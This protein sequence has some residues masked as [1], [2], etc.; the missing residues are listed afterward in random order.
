MK[1]LKYIAVALFFSLLTVGLIV[2]SVPT[3]QAQANAESKNLSEFVALMQYIRSQPTPSDVLSNKIAELGPLD[4]FFTDIYI[5]GFITPFTG[6]SAE[7]AEAR[8]DSLPEDDRYIAAMVESYRLASNPLLLD[9]LHA[10]LARYYVELFTTA[11]L[12]GAPNFLGKSEIQTLADEFSSSAFVPPAPSAPGASVRPS[13]SSRSASD[14]QSA[15]LSEFAALMQYIRSQPT[16]SDVLSNKIAELG[17]LDGFFTDIY[18]DG[19]ITPFTGESAEEA[20]A[21]IDSLPEDDRYI[22]AMVE[23]YRLASNP[24]LLDI[25]HAVLA[26]YY[27]E[28]FTTA[29]LSGAPN[30]LGKSEIQT[31]ADDFDPEDYE[32]AMPSE[33][34]TVGDQVIDA[35]FGRLEVRSRGE[36]GRP[37]DSRVRVYEQASGTHLSTRDTGSDGLVTFYLRQGVY[38]VTVTET[39][40]IAVE[41]ID[42]E[43]GETSQVGVD[44][45]QLVL[46]YAE[47]AR[48]RLYDQASGT[49]LST[50]DVGSDGRASWHLRA[51]TYRVTTSNPAE[52]FTEISVLAGQTTVI[53]ETFNHPPVIES[54]SARPHLIKAGESTVI[55]VRASDK[56]LDTLTYTYTPSVGT[57]T[58]AGSRV[59]Y[60]APNTGGVYRID[61][62][63]SDGRG[64]VARTTLYVSGG[65]LKVTSLGGDD[66]RPLDSRV[67]VYEQASG[68]HVSTRDTGSDGVVE[69]R[70]IQG[71]YRITVSE[72]NS[73]SVDNLEVSPDRETAAQVFFGRLEVR[74]RGEG[75][76]P[77]DSRVRVYEQ[78]SGTHLST[79]DTGS[80]GLVTFYLRQGVYRVTVTET[81]AIAVENIDVEGGETS[82]VGV[83]FGQLV[84]IY[85][86]TA[87]ARLYD[88]AS[89]THLSTRDVGSDGRASWHLRAGTYRV[90]TSNPAEEFTEI[91]VLAGQTTVIGETFNHPPVIESAS[92]RPHLIKAGESTVITVRASDKDLDTLTYT[93]TPSVGTITGAGSRVTYTAPNTGGVYRIDIEV[94]D[95][96]GGVARTTLYVS[97]GVLKVTSLGGD[98]ERPLDS[99][100]RVYEQASG[101]HVSTRDTGSDGVVEFRLIQGTYRITVSETNSISVDNLE[102]SPD[103]ETA[104]QVFFGRLEVRSRGEGSRPLDSRVRVYE[105]ASGTHLSTRDTGSD[106]LV[107]FYLRQGVY[108]V[109]VTE[110]NAIAVENIDVEGGETSQV[111][112]DFGQLVLIYAETARA[113]LYDQASG[114]HLSTRDVGSDGRASWHLRAGTYRVTTSNPAEEFTEISVLAGQTTVIGETF[115]HPPVIE[116]ASARPHLIKAGESTVITV[117]ASDKDLDTLTYTYTPSVGTI[118]GAGSRV[119]YTAPNTGG[120]YRIDIEVSDGRGGVA[121][122]TLYVSGGVLKVT[123][124]GGD[125]ERPL[126]SRVRVYEQASGTHVSTRD[127]GS[128]GVVEFRLIQGTYRITVSET[129]SISVDNLEVSPDRETAAQV[130]F[131][132]LE[133]RSRGE[134]SRPLDSRV[135][136]YEQASGTHLS[137]RDTGSDGLVTFYLRQGVYRVTVTETNAIAVENIQMATLRNVVVEVKEGVTTY[138]AQGGNRPPSI[139]NVVVRQIDQDTFTLAVRASDPDDDEL[140][141]SFTT[142]SSATI[143]ASGMDATVDLVDDRPVTIQITV[144]DGSGGVATAS[145]VI[146]PPSN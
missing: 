115:N 119:T 19:F 84:L 54:A 144:S 94:S 61:I 26:R 93:Y 81:N 75:S 96:R 118:T 82:Q 44:F 40:A 50:R 68:T 14:V 134:G 51:G 112:V 36:G 128:D 133:V 53:G 126:D 117:R 97:G 113:R 137:T 109:T 16:P 99:R 59:T 28:L 18:I 125:D 103:R 10:V 56:D 37:L 135:R 102:V 120:V 20:E 132:R 67:R 3:A 33:S 1:R 43:G 2:G 78:A 123:S 25:L 142:L 141:A 70:L 116:S 129:N 121:R 64:G 46:I 31:L 111:G 49:H 29:D 4:G 136:V 122:T 140:E 69:F 79:R 74:S 13:P 108:R 110:T 45:G 27:V 42:V 58:G 92:A 143:N 104:A 146:E 139:L 39:N 9:I 21:R 34:T 11:D 101:T 88:Q 77:L 138:T 48:A 22:A 35:T 6:E 127:T 107:T 106:G 15:N 60:T 95:G 5:D 114:T 71:T 73:I 85:A 65:V 83:D 145:V 91:S 90:T 124:L 72:T 12:S 8:I 24:L 130:F 100:V 105:Q 80:D 89:G 57:I 41:N 38:R 63:V 87:R 98:D 32:I 131:G 62:E 55:T 17:P 30:F 23:S 76:R 7:E 66:E 47:T 86:E 52:E